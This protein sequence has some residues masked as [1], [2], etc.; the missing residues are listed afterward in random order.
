MFTIV[1]T[2]LLA[3]AIVIIGV[4]FTLLLNERDE[5]ESR[6]DMAFDLAQQYKV[7]EK[8]LE[9]RTERHLR[10]SGYIQRQRALLEEKDVALNRA[11]QLLELFLESSPDFEKDINITRKQA[12]RL[13]VA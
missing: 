7:L 6:F 12:R 8:R 1:L 2:V 9:K 13:F 5:S 10:A 3:I 4:L 11:N